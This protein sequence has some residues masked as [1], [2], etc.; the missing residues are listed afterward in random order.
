MDPSMDRLAQKL[1]CQSM[2]SGLGSKAVHLDLCHGNKNMGTDG[3][4]TIY[5]NIKTCWTCRMSRQRPAKWHLMAR[6]R[7]E[8]WKWTKCGRNVKILK[9]KDWTLM[10]LRQQLNMQV[11]RLRCLWEGHD[12]GF[13][14]IHQTREFSGF[15]SQLFQN[16]PLKQRMNQVQ[17]LGPVGCRCKKNEGDIPNISWSVDPWL[18]EA[19][20]LSGTSHIS[21]PR[22]WASQDRTVQPRTAH[23]SSRIMASWSYHVSSSLKYT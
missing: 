11:C 15:R 21:S 23:P 14:A 9:W 1:R 10:T 18:H 3:K 4:H 8:I 22:K 7:M 6:N 2:H 17:I 19:R 5:Y 12:H 20:D 16:L 13:T